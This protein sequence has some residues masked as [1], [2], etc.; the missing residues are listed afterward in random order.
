MYQSSGQKCLSAKTLK[1]FETALPTYKRVYKSALVNP[2]F[3]SEV[4]VY[5]DNL[6]GIVL[7]KDRTELPLSRRRWSLLADQLKAFFND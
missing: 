7:L 5:S 3:I 2:E 4:R 1:I 6:S